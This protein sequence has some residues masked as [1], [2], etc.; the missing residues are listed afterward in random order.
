MTECTREQAKIA[1]EEKRHTDCEWALL[2]SP[3]L[4]VATLRRRPDQFGQHRHFS[5]PTKNSLE[6]I[7]D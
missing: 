4:G 3:A 1:T 2:E 7:K 5:I 6:V